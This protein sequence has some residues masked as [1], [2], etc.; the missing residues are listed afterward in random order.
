MLVQILQLV[1]S[2]KQHPEADKLYV[3]TIDLG[4]ENP[5]TVVS[6]LVGRVAMEELLNRSV[7]V[8][9]NLKP[10]KMRNVL[11]QAMLLC[12]STYVK[13]IYSFLQYQCPNPV[14]L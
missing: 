5:R 10:A 11:S 13:N 6:G 3:E 1:H 2:I 8:L 9:C 12:A 7:V 4:E 14:S